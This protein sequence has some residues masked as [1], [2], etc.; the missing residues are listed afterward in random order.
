[1]LSFTYT[2]NPSTCEYIHTYLHK[3]IDRDTS[4]RTHIHATYIQTYIHTDAYTYMRIHIHW[5]T[6][7]P[8]GGLIHR[9]TF[10]S[11]QNLA[12]IYCPF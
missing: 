7:V 5:V 8:L 2:I 4:T 12:N 1:M 10:V 11:L 3:Y 6:N 9:H